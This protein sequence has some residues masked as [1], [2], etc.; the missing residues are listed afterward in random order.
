MKLPAPPPTDSLS[1]PLKVAILSRDPETVK[2]FDELRDA[3][4]SRLETQIWPADATHLPAMVEQEQPG[5]VLL[6]TAGSH[7]DELQALERV[8]ARQPGL[9]VILI[10]ARR[11]PDFLLAAMRLGVREVL[12]SPLA[13]GVL[14]HAVNRLRERISLAG[15]TRPP[16]QVVAIMPCK[17]GSG[18]TFIATNLACAIAAGHRRVCLIDLNLHFGD[19]ALYVSEQTPSST[20][21]DVVAQIQRL[22]GALLEANMLRINPWFELLAAPD[23]PAQAIDVRPEHIERLIAVARHA[24]DFVLLDVSRTLDL[25]SV[26]ALDGADRIYL[27]LQATL[28]FIRDAARLLQMF[29]ALG[30]PREKTQWLLNRFDRQSE[31]GPEDIEKTLGLPPAARIPNRFAVVAESINHGRPVIELAARDPVSRSLLEL[32]A[33]LGPAETGHAAWWQ[34]LIGRAA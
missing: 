32:A 9:A 7:E 12:Q 34:R 33:T 14:S 30:Y 11:D 2:Q 24:Y 20:V 6:E 26:R 17:G 19:A 13:P 15:R 31:I 16:G 27:V 28:P 23:S 21:A 29:G 3:T 25:N 1:P 5:L 10:C 8:L 4:G 22:D 18:A